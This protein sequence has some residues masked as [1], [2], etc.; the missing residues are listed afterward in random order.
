MIFNKFSVR[1]LLRF[2]RRRCG[3]R[4]EKT[5]GAGGFMGNLPARSGQDRDTF[6]GVPPLAGVPVSP[7]LFPNMCEACES[8]EKEIDRLKAFKKRIGKKCG[9]VLRKGYWADYYEQN[10]ETILAKARERW[11]KGRKVEM[12]QDEANAITPPPKFK[13]P[14]KLNFKSE[15]NLSRAE[16]A[17]TR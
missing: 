16:P 13:R 5:A 4:T 12:P 8:I 7:G 14:A 10:R 6:T 2:W 17:A 9:R 11:A 1:C 3:D 15:K